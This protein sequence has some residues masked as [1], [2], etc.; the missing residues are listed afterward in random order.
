MATKIGNIGGPA[1]VLDVLHTRDPY[2]KFTVYWPRKSPFPDWWPTTWTRSR[3]N[4]AS[5]RSG[6]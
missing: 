5:T 3:P 1:K 6:S 4:S 2:V